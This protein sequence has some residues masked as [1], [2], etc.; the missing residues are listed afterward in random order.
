MAYVIRLGASGWEACSGGFASSQFGRKWIFCSSGGWGWVWELE[1]WRWRRA[2]EYYRGHCTA[3]W[4]LGWQHWRWAEWDW[5]WIWAF[6]L[7]SVVLPSPSFRPQ[8]TARNI[9]IYCFML[10]LYIYF[11][12]LAA[13]YFLWLNKELILH[14]QL[15]SNKIRGGMSHSNLE[16]MPR[17]GHPIQLN[18][19]NIM[20][21]PTLTQ[22]ICQGWDVPFSWVYQGWDVPFNWIYQGWD[23]PLSLGVYAKDGMSHSAQYTKDGTSHFDLEYNTSE[24]WCIKMWTVTAQLVHMVSPWTLYLY[25]CR[26]SVQQWKSAMCWCLHW[27]LDHLTIYNSMHG[28]PQ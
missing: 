21:H 25:I 26:A 2:A 7:R 23:I 10:H 6:G 11:D 13:L 4:I 20:G 24:L 19:P 8:T 15:I 5:F 12:N 1:W 22:S 9:V 28:M 27:F 3:R 18:I 17:M 16:Y 14:K